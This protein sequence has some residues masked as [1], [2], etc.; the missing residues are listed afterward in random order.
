MQTKSVRESLGCWC[1]FQL[2]THAEDC[3]SLLFLQ[4]DPQ[5][6]NPLLCSILG[7]CGT[8]V[9]QQMV[10]SSSRV[11]NR[12]QLC[13]QSALRWWWWVYS[14]PVQKRHLLP[15]LPEGLRC[16]AD[17]LSVMM[18]ILTQF[19]VSL[20]RSYGHLGHDELDCQCGFGLHFPDG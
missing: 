10:V 16:S 3:G 17:L 1:R 11:Q 5:I 9:R 2:S 19:S 18:P 12:S 6:N 8:L 7:Y 4:V 14:W 20:I 13:G 15:L